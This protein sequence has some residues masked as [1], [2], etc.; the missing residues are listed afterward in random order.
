M[1]SVWQ[2]QTVILGQ[3]GLLRLLKRKMKSMENS[4]GRSPPL[5][6]KR[7]WHW[8]LFALWKILSQNT[9]CLNSTK[10]G[11]H[12]RV[13]EVQVALNRCATSYLSKISL[14]FKTWLLSMNSPNSP[15]PPDSGHTANFPEKTRARGLNYTSTL[16]PTTSLR[17]HLYPH[18]FLPLVLQWSSFQ[19][20]I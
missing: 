7:I 4:L 19:F 9:G 10:S 15:L 8:G 20:K 1:N 12:L 11:H 16:E 2:E 18:I 13:M 14:R 3:W 5:L 17:S 6:Q